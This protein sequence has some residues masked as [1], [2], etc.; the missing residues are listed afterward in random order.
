MI[1]ITSLTGPVKGGREHRETSGCDSR[2]G[3]REA[4]I[5]GFATVG[6]R[7]RGTS[8]AAQRGRWARIGKRGVA[9]QVWMEQSVCG[10]GEQKTE[11]EGRR[12]SPKETE[13]RGLRGE[14]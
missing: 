7:V 1:R 11:A 12:R 5:G 6:G 2:R 9:G 13:R 14:R 8:R 4:G 10:K 3:K